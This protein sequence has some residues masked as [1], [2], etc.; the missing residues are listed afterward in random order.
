MPVIK[1]YDISTVEEVK[2]IHSDMKKTQENNKYE[3][4][5]KENIMLVRTTDDFPENRVMKTLANRS[6]MVKNQMNFIVYSPYFM[7]LT[8]DQIEKLKTYVLHY[9][10]TLHLTENS[11]VES[12]EYGNFSNRPFIFL[13]PL[14]YHEDKIINY[15]GH[16]TFTQGNVILSNEAILIM[17]EDQYYKYREIYPDIDTYNVVLYKGISKEDKEHYLNTSEADIPSFDINDERA[18]VQKTLIDL[19]YTPELLSS[20]YIISSPTSDKINEINKQLATEHNVLYWTNHSS[21]D[22]YKEDFQKNVEI[23]EILDKQLLD[24]IL[25]NHNYTIDMLP[26]PVKYDCYLAAYLINTFTLESIIKDIELFNATMEYMNQNNLLP[27]SEELL[28]GNVPN[29]F[30]TYVQQLNNTESVSLK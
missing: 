26:Q 14:I 16:D 13:D 7:D 12:H 21:T 28:N 27:T 20:H 22:N 8:R 29:I 19:G 9:R 1:E 10:S 6:L 2:K 24:F 11:L 17:K 30:D 4:F 3:T 25:S 18:A 23:T 15:A 5:T